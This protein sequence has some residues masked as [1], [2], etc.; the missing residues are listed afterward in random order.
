MATTFRDILDIV[1]ERYP[2]TKSAEIRRQF[3]DA[4]EKAHVIEYIQEQ[5]NY[6]MTGNEGLHPDD[7]A[8]IKKPETKES[9]TETLSEALDILINHQSKRRKQ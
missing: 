7:V 9:K 6:Q 2:N 4:L 8:P 3:L 5:M 1:C